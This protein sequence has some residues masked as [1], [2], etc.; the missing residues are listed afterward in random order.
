MCFGLHRGEVC[1]LS[2][3]SSLVCFWTTN[4]RV[5]TWFLLIPNTFCCLCEMLLLITALPIMFHVIDSHSLFCI[6]HVVN[7]LMIG[8]F[9][10]HAICLVFICCCK[11]I[12]HCILSLVHYL[13]L[14]RDRER[15][16]WWLRMEQVVI[17]AILC[18]RK[19]L[20]QLILIN[21]VLLTVFICWNW[22]KTELLLRGG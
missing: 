4:F 12:I 7:V 1:R 17:V 2:L 16:M 18:R 14:S 13:S 19:K 5:L 9:S 11:T 8:N 21:G 15:K 6:E 22:E 20:W 10:W 3:S